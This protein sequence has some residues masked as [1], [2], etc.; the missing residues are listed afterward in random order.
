MLSIVRDITQRKQVEEAL[1]QS[2][3]RFRNAFDAAA[4][5]MCIVGLDEQLLEANLPFCQMLGYTEAEILGL[6]IAEI[7]YDTD[8]LQLDRDYSQQLLSGQI[9]YFHL[10]KRYRHKAGC[11]LWGHLSVS[12]VRDQNHQP[13]YYVAQVQDITQRKRAEADLRETHEILQAVIQSSPVGIN[14][15]APDGTVK[16]WNPAAEEIFGWRAAEVLGKPLPIIPVAQQATFPD[17]LEREFAGHG[18]SPVEVQ[19]QHKNG[20]LLDIS[21]STAILRDPNGQIIGSLGIFIDVTDR[22]WAEAELTTLTYRLSTLV[23]GMQSGILLETESRQVVIANQSF[24][25]VFGIACTLESLMGNNSQHML[26]D[27]Q[28]IFQDPRQVFDR[29]TEILAN[30][31][32]IMGEEVLLTDGRTLERDYIPILGGGEYPEH[33]WQYRDITDRKQI[34][35]QL[36]QSKNAAEAAN[37]A[38]S[39]FLA[40][41][42]MKFVPL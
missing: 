37:N 28:Q 22:K 40:M 21:L 11:I 17:W 13:L 33:L 29:M 31:T 2:E 32:P 20:Q 16:L 30:R 24:C 8:D 4:I 15:I 18:C 14:I 35:L 27:N 3:Q 26:E 39:D 6:S 42:S 9:P 38:K 1:R 41:M 23:T 36:E 10:E 25:D 34:Q 5:G 19:R 7:T 12:L